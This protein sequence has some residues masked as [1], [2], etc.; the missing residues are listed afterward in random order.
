MI[1]GYDLAV[2]KISGPMNAAFDEVLK[3]E[4]FIN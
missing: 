2:R 3:V 4:T 1:G